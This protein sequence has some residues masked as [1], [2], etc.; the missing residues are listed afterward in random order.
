[1][2]FLLACFLPVSDLGSYCCFLPVVELWTCW[3]TFFRIW[4][5]LPNPWPFFGCVSA[6]SFQE[7]LIR[8]MLQIENTFFDLASQCS[9]NCLVI[10]DRGI[11]DASACK[12]SP[13]LSTL[14]VPHSQATWSVVLEIRRCVLL[15]VYVMFLTGRPLLWLYLKVA[16]SDLYV[17]GH[18]FLTQRWGV[19]SANVH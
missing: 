8:T 15:I 7:N 3:C 1:M 11:M 9:Q 4:P 12:Y 18:S 13:P 16:R 5:L 10:C 2:I 14:F 6:Y 17:T 19:S